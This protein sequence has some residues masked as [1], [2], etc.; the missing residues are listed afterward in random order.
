MSGKLATV[1]A[2][3]SVA[4]AMAA[5]W[6]PGHAAAAAQPGDTVVHVPCD[7]AALASDIAGAAQTETL[8]LAA[9]CVYQLTQGLVTNGGL[10]L[11]IEGNGA[12]LERSYAAGTPSFTIL[13]DNEYGLTTTSLNFR[14]GRGAIYVSP[15]KSL[16][17]EGGTFSANSADS[18]GA[19]AGGGPESAVTVDGAT[20]MGNKAARYGGAIADS[21]I[22]GIVVTNSWFYANQAAWG[23]AIYNGSLTGETFTGVVLRGNQASEDGG[24]IYSSYSQVS[25]TS[26]QLTSNIAGGRGGAIYTE[27]VSDGPDQM[28]TGLTGTTVRD[29]SAAQGGGIYASQSITDVTRGSI[30]GNHAS[31]A[32]GG[33]FSEGDPSGEFGTVTLSQTTLSGN[34][35]R[36]QGGGVY[37]EG[38]LTAANTSFTGNSASGGGAVYDHDLFGPGTATATLTSSPTRR[39]T[40]DNCEPAGTVHGCTG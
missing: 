19:I 7:P 34:A 10:T 14:N 21:N 15:G 30:T 17:V 2:A 27:G 29:N 12:T 4:A 13:Q 11:N 38:T 24:A 22:F 20:F 39:N 37:N 33:I 25:L 35:A 5:G 9:G 23:G 31:G 3:A 32:G 18:G 1:A 36:K 16:T 26:S 8:D 40:P 6:L 28:G